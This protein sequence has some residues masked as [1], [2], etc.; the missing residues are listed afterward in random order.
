MFD[1]QKKYG[2]LGLAR[3][4][5]AAAY[6]IK[7]LGGKAFLS[8]YKTE[9]EIQ[10]SAQLKADFECEFGQHSDRLFECDEWIVSPGIPL[11]AEIIVQGREH[12][13]KMISELEFGYQIKSPDSQIIAITGSNGKSTTASL[14][15]HIIKKSGKN[16]IL[17]GNIGDAIC[18]FPIEKPGIDFIV[19]EVSS[20]QLDLIDTFKPEIGLV[21]NITPDHLNRYDSFK[22]YALSKMNIFKNQTQENH[23]I[24]NMDDVVIEG[25]ENHIHSKK[26]YFTLET[27]N[28]FRDIPDIWLNNCFLEY[29]QGTSKY[30]VY[31]M[32]LKGP[33]NWANAMASII[34]CNLAQIPDSVI[35]EGL[36]DFPSLTHRLQ[37][38]N[39]VKG[40]SFYNDSKATNT[41][42]VKCAL[43]SFEQPIRIIMGGSDKGEDFSVMADLLAEKAKK[44]YVTGETATKMH[45]AWFGKVPIVLI[46]DFE[47]CVRQAYA[48]SD[49]GEVIVLSPACASF[50][51]FKNYEHR[52]EVFTSIVKRIAE[53]NEEKK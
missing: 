41:D 20:F 33:H 30:S 22:D 40:V 48:D 52:G 50:D 2:I 12:N 24:L 9:S 44:V 18:G 42:S 46:D 43:L 8:E 21:L 7:S 26:H 10:T 3:S 49:V 4:G 39:S 1:T 13:I 53:E 25:L 51:K 47:A 38:V 11:T 16:C 29:N 14:I 32:Q 17:A 19:L 37:F 36:T 6:K 45:Q 15:A 5:I 27:V 35:F 31:D 23:A 28:K 34:A